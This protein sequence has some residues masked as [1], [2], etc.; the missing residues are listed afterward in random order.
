MRVAADLVVLRS[1]EDCR[2]ASSWIDCLIEAARLRMVRTD[3]VLFIII[4]VKYLL[5]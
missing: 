4:N 1:C 2:Y 5:L 3:L